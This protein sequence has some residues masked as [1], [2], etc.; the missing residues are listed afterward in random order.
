M[1]NIGFKNYITE[2]RD[3]IEG[4]VEDHQ[5]FLMPSDLDI[6]VYAMAPPFSLDASN[7]NNVFMQKLAP[8]DRKVNLLKAVDQFLAIYQFATNNSMIY[9]VPSRPG[10][11][12][13]P[14]VANLGINLPHVQDN[15]IVVSNYKS[16]PRRGETSVGLHF[17]ED[18]GY[19]TVVAPPYFEGEADLKFLNKNNYCGAYGMR[20]S[21]NALDWF[22]KSYDMNIIPIKIDDPELY[23]LDCVIF[24]LQSDKMFV[25]ESAVDK[26]TKRKIEK[27]VDI[28]PIDD[29]A[30]HCGITNCV[31][32]G[33]LI[34]NGTNIETL[35]KTDDQY[36]K[37]KYKNDTLEK[38]CANNAYDVVFFNISEFAKSG[39]D[40]S[41]MFMHLNYPE[42][43]Q[44]PR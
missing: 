7:P 33:S 24:P 43:L 3:D 38:I 25:V 17:F 16:E 8:K 32:M 21:M 36:D 40:L 26:S 31:R 44:E 9:L 20:T 30:G 14:Y 34:L 39:A 12:D 6:P 11:G 42:L 15:T 37:E 27:Y 13:L 2:K 10:L 23:H 28:I 4:G 18:I 22:S 5:R 19:K 41:C 35:K 29:K 1:K